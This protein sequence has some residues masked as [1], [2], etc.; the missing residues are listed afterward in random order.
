LNTGDIDVLRAGM[1]LGK[2]TLTG[3]FAPSI[4]GLTLNDEAA[5]AT[6][7]EVSTATATEILRRVGG[8]AGDLTL[9]GADTHTGTVAT[10][11]TVTM[12]NCVPATGVITVGAITNAIS[13]GSCVCPSDG[14]ITRLITFW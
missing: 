4:F 1:I 2:I 14:S 7:I 13:A 6:T 9:I 12:S 8:V 11:E 10:V 5:G 3:L